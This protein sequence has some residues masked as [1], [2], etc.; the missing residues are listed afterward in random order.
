MKYSNL[1]LW[2]MSVNQSDSR[3]STLFTSPSVTLA[4]GGDFFL[5]LWTDRINLWGKRNKRSS[6]MTPQ[7]VHPHLISFRSVFNWPWSCSLTSICSS[8]SLCSFFLACSRRS[9]S[10]SASS[11]CL[12]AVFSLWVS[13]RVRQKWDIYTWAKLL[14]N[15]FSF[16]LLWL[17]W[18]LSLCRFKCSSSACIFISFTLRSSLRLPCCRLLLCL[19][20][21]GRERD[22]I[23]TVASCNSTPS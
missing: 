1:F 12:F 5:R 20:V 17:T 3:P 6:Y 19:S 23:A 22:H 13:C 10:S 9:I 4:R 15:F 8:S 7:V 16:L 2:H 14:E 11:I 21:C 18:S